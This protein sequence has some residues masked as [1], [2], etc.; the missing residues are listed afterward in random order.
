MRSI[1]TLLSLL[2]TFSSVL[3]AQ[4]PI[5]EP[6]VAI[7]ILSSTDYSVVRATATDAAGDVYVTGIFSGTIRI[8]AVTMTSTRTGAGYYDNDIFVAK[9]RP[10]TRTF[11]WA[12]QAGGLGNDIVN[13]LVV[14]GNSI[15]VTGR[16]NGATSTFGSTVL[17][18]SNPPTPISTTDDIFLAKLTDTGTTATFAWA[19]SVGNQY[20]DNAICLAPVA[21]GSGVYMAG[22]LGDYL[23]VT[24]VVNS[25][26]GS[27][28]AW[29]MNTTAPYTTA[30][31][32]A[33]SGAN[34]YV[35]GDFRYHLFLG[36]THLITSGIS[37][38]AYVAKLTDTGPTAEWNWALQAGGSNTDHAVGLTA[39]GSNVY[40]AGNY[41][42]PTINF[43]TL[44]LSKGTSGYNVFVA[45]VSDVGPV[46]TFE[47]ARSATG[48]GDVMAY[49]LTMQGNSLY[50]VG[51]FTQLAFFG[52]TTLT[53]V[54]YEDLFVAKLT[55]AGTATAWNWAQQA[56]GDFEDDAL[57]VAVSGTKVYVG[58]LTIS[59]QADFGSYI[60]PVIKSNGMGF[61][62]SLT[63]NVTTVTQAPLVTPGLQFYPNPAH[64][65]VQVPG[66]TAAT[67]LTL[68]DA[69]GRTVRTA[70]GSGLSV[71][72]VTP[73]LYVLHATTPGQPT[74]VARLVVE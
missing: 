60:L 9:W 33:V 64:T 74:R 69:L 48:P 29:T 56:G 10:V 70:L 46:G 31:A 26:P 23:F 55:D 52:T 49:G 39:S 3:R 1:L 37:T 42:S 50:M 72:S 7:N 63:G 71:Q 51:A 73:G 66:A 5:W 65:A 14:Q 44:S 40:V 45:K 13:G 16:F 41:S 30:T 67:V 32:L 57:A 2:L 62:A 27:L 36:T 53:S 28:V 38:D 59:T 22:A 17:T 8:G 4:V 6:P 20:D 15:Y 24:K 21:D 25:G 58:G 19:R 43:G 11:V 12:Q 61:L 35:T 34:V 47:W 18:N 68:T 54:K